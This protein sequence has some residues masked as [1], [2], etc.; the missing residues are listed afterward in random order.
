[1]EVEP[2]QDKFV[3]KLTDPAKI[4]HAR[5]ILSGKEKER[6]RVQGRIVKQA[7]A[8]NPPWSFHYD[9]QSIEFFAAAV[10]VCDSS[11]AYVESFLDEAG[12]AYLPGNIWCPWASRL[13][14]EIPPPAV[15]SGLISTSA[16]SYK[17][18]GLAPESIVAAYGSELALT[19]E[20]ATTLPLPEKLAGTTVKLKDSAGSERFAPLFFVSPAQ[21]NYLAPAGTAP[22]LATVTV[23]NANNVVVS[24]WTQVLNIAPGLFTANSGGWGPPAGFAVRVK[25]DGSQRFEPLAHYDAAKKE[26]V[27]AELDLGPEGEQIFLMLFGT[28]LRRPGVAAPLAKIGD[29][30]AEVLFIGGVPGFAGLDQV[31]LRVPR[32]LIGH[33][34]VKVVLLADEKKANPVVVKIK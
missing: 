14:K 30:A 18:L 33:G 20:V 8:W 27:P 26:F 2:R 1:M 10:E 29:L 11:V 16:A 12:G 7:A 34:E 13:L 22:G 28:G 4:Q 31:N 5:D 32:E 9:P 15:N 23:T 6:I 17:R 21:V 25:A 24:E 3:I 19:T